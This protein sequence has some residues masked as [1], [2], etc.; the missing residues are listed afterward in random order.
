MNQRG[1]VTSKVMIGQPTELARDD[2]SKL[3]RG[4]R[5]TGNVQKLRS[6]HHEIARLSAQ[7]FTGVEVAGLTGYTK[8][9]VG[10]LLNSPAMVELVAIYRERRADAQQEQFDAYLMLKTNNM[11][12]AERHIA[13]HIADLD[14]SNELLPV[15]TALAIS[16][17]GADRTGYGKRQTV[18]VNHDFA[19]ALEKAIARSGKIV[20]VTPT[21]SVPRH[22]SS[23]APPP[24]SSRNSEP[25]AA[26][27]PLIRRRA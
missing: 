9:R 26:E 14:D 27:R 17:D 11:I 23:Q 12:A 21:P 25:E 16:A 19:A 24:A 3:E 8:E 13:D 10:Q 22:L 2:L 15:K 7:G 4:N 1:T 5:T 18:N 6:S 20:D